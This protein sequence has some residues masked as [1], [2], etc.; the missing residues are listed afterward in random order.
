M[1]HAKWWHH[2]VMFSHLHFQSVGVGEELKQELEWQTCNKGFWDSA[3]WD[4]G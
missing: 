3:E 4:A 1:A 2:W